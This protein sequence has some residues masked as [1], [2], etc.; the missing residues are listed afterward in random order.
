MFDFEDND[1]PL[2]E[3]RNPSLPDLPPMTLDTDTSKSPERA[4]QLKS[5]SDLVERRLVEMHA[6]DAPS[7]RAAWRGN[8]DKMRSV[9]V[10]QTRPM[11]DSMISGSGIDDLPETE[12]SIYASSMPINIVSPRDM[13]RLT[14][15]EPKTSL[16]EREGIMVPPLRAAM[17]QGT[18][19]VTGED[20]LKLEIGVSTERPRAIPEQ[21]LS[22]IAR[23]RQG[24][25]GSLNPAIVHS[26]SSSA[27]YSLRERAPSFAMDPGPALESEGSDEGMIPP[28]EAV[29]GASFVP[30]HRMELE[31]QGS[32]PGWRSMV[33]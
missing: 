27:A 33:G 4:Q 8:K 31:R 9:L 23:Q 26:R 24:S 22:P 25:A 10:Q 17:R 15:Y 11:V 7:H 13:S 32:D 5:G 16:T 30:P 28:E 21:S 1:V 19:V 12:T 29:G 20:K 2:D 6:A 3:Q 14:R 18:S